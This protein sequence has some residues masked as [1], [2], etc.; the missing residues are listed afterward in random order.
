VGLT[1]ALLRAGAAR[2]HVLLAAVP[3]G[4]EVRLAAEAELRRRGWPAAIS[5]ADADV[6]LVAGA[7]PGELDDLIEAVWRA[8]PAP[9][10]RVQAL[11]PDEIR[12]VLDDARMLVGD[13]S[14]QH[15][16]LPVPR[17]PLIR[18]VPEAGGLRSGD[19]G[20]AD[21]M[22]LPGGIQTPG[23]P[24]M[25]DGMDMGGAMDMADAMDMGGGMHM[26]SGMHGMQMPSG[27]P[28]ASPG[29]D[30]DGLKLDQLHVPLGPFLPDWPTGLVVRVT[31][32]GDVIQHATA[33]VLGA[34]REG[35]SY[36]SQPWLRAAAADRP[37]AGEAARGFA[38]R[39]GR[40]RVLAWA[41]RA[42][43]C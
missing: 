24:D 6:L 40:S 5:P 38:R 9:R 19:S 31:L 32:Q 10:A 27:L 34:I 23:G 37:G 1:R 35:R 22:Q 8:V 12:A 2:P 3:G 33:E 42:W 11:S 13:L 14:R 15:A 16:A 29:E 17:D 26:H 25:P 28:T 41:T 43:G 20:G 36:W 7:V 39:V 4:T 18:D 30:R 21:G